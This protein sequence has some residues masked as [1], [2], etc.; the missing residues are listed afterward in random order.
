[1]L[2]SKIRTVGDL[3]RAVES[4]ALPHRSVHEEVRQ[5]LIRKLRAGEAVTPE[6]LQ[7]I[8]VRPS[9]AELNVAHVVN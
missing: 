7:A 6:S 3:R 8:Y 1:M 2:N 9:D 5:N 4:G